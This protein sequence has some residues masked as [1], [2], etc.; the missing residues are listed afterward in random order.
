MR[1]R[2]PTTA[3]YAITACLVLSTTT[4]CDPPKPPRPLQIEPAP[5]SPPSPAVETPPLASDKVLAKAPLEAPS[6]PDAPT[7]D[8]GPAGPKPP[9]PPV[10][11]EL[12]PPA[13][14]RLTGFSAAEVVKTKVESYFQ[15]K[16]GRRIH[17]QTDKPLYKPGETI[18]V[19][20]W[21]VTTRALSGK[22][23]S[24]GMHVE[25]VSPRGAQV[26]KK[27]VHENA[28][29]GQID[30]VLDGGIVGGEYKLKVKT[31]DGVQEER[32]LIVST[33]DPPKLKLKLEFVRKAYG[34][35]DEVTATIAVKR[36]TGEPL[37]NHGLTATVMLDGQALPQVQLRTDE[38]GD[39]LVRFNL[40]A[41]ISQG[42]G[43]LTVMADDGGITESIAKRVPILV[44]KLQLSLY[45]EGGELVS[46]LPGRVYFEAKNPIGKPADI[47]GRVLDENDQ[48]MASFESVRDGLG[49]VDFTP[50][51]GHRYTVAVDQPVGI[52]DR[53]VLPTPQEQGCVLRSVDDLDGQLTATRV[54]VRCSDRRKVVV[55]ATLRESLLD[56]A[57][58]EADRD[59]AVVYLEPRGQGTEALGRA[60]GAVRVTLF[61][62]SYLPLAE[63]LV[64]RQRRAR[65]QVEVAPQK[66]SFVP[67]EK[68][69]L[70]VTT[71]DPAGNPVPADLA[72]SIVDD[73]V[74]SF[75]DDKTGN[76]LSRLYLEPELTGKV[77]EPNF[78]FDL[79]EKKSALA[80]DLLMG[81]RGYRRFEWRPVLGGLIA[82]A[83]AKASAAGEGTA[84]TV[85]GFA[86]LRK[87]GRTLPPADA[88]KADPQKDAPKL[89]LAANKPADVA[90]KG[91][92]APAQPVTAAA[93]PMVMADNKPAT[94]GPMLG[95][96]AAPQRQ[97]A[98]GGMAMAPAA[99][100]AVAQAAMAPAKMHAEMAAEGSVAPMEMKADKAARP[101][102][103][104]MMARK[105][106]EAPMGRAARDDVDGL[107]GFADEIGGG[108]GHGMRPV[109]PMPRPRPRPRPVEPW[110]PVRVFPVPAY[111]PDYSGPRTDFRETIF[112][113]PAVQ[114]GQD[115][116]AQV[117]FFLSD[118]VTSFRV[119]TEAIG[120]GAAGRDE[121]VVKSSLPF[122]MAV[123]LPTE[124]SEGDRIALPL[125]LVN[126]RDRP[127]QV[128]LSAQFGSLLKLER[129]VERAQGLIAPM[130]RD[131]LFYPLTVSGKKGKT[132]I[133]FVADAAGLRD[134]FVREIAVAP[135]G[136]PQTVSKSGRLK[137]SLSHELE[138]A[139]LMEG[140]A[141]GQLKVYISQVSTLIGGLDGMLSEPGGCFEQASS[142]NYPN[143]MILRYLKTAQ[144]AA[145]RVTAR[146][147]ALL[148]DGYKLLTGYET[149]TK[150]YEWFGSTPGHEAL[151]AYGL[152][153]FTD[154]KQVFPEVS[155]AMIKRTADWL[156]A[157]RD[158]KGGFHRDAKSLDSF[159]SA[160][161][162]VTDAYITYSVSEAK[163]PGFEREL[164]AQEQVARET[165]DP[166]ILSLA[167]NTLFN[168][169]RKDTG[170]AAAK[171]LSS[172]Q[173]PSG[174]WKGASHSITRSGG[175]DLQIETTSLAMLA[176]L[177]SGQFDDSVEKGM[178]WLMQKRGGHGSFGATQATVLALKAI[179]AY[180]SA[181]A[182]ALTP[183]T[184]TLVINSKEVGQKSY[185]PGDREPLTFPGLAK[186]LVAG[187]NRVEIRH[188]GQTP[189]PYS[190]GLSY[191]SE[192]PAT[193]PDTKVALTTTL[194]RNQ[195]KLG[196][197]VR[198]EVTLTNK[199]DQG[200]PMTLA[201]IEIPGGLQFQ[202]WQLKELREKGLIG[203]YE[204]RP[205]QVNLY[206][207]QMQPKQEVKLPLDLMATVPG[208]YTAQA[209]TAY[210]YYTSE[211]KAWVAGTKIAIE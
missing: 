125:I 32:P 121:T 119:Q 45:P 11:A 25:L 31:F 58:V 169:G 38:E 18:W 200:L 103:E 195:V 117:S 133:R 151:T 28:G 167:V 40:P 63:R 95:G 79:S 203:F 170:Y 171:R 141:D 162:A 98:G 43:L 188:S 80:L 168:A 27:R 206:L 123:K 59:P 20:V 44:K 77:E 37:R 129:P 33:Y 201:R 2:R 139:G 116:K 190:L 150:G 159:G 145:P 86:D 61:D 85:T 142:T 204:T 132:E 154:M 23:A 185:Q 34:P 122:S 152:V 3:L 164:D 191:R 17:I 88:P 160:S 1:L 76:M 62:E 175:T 149:P 156:H 81:T 4:F 197:S 49:R 120:G 127:V 10:P 208:D 93:K 186:Y 176:L 115:G 184:V 46:G 51:P 210:L 50:Q 189:L 21:D 131:A 48:T 183:G 166:Y 12:A 73:T 7:V 82:Q 153:E 207:R 101:A 163:Q 29:A 130:A 177:K 94:R 148:G 42:D 71:R 36:N 100:P 91:T 52:V 75:A 9:L 35:G 68:V 97:G 114:T 13:S 209:S 165:Q 158:G 157:R 211:H 161:K 14:P 147:H 110:A 83:K 41:D 198:M 60:Q 172:L 69:T 57:A 109:M 194:A 106:M 30:F 99:P 113:S 108:R 65:L 6:P 134:E 174:V 199:T 102:A 182:R 135:R 72:L 173:D 56:V 47:A 89:V 146:A 64:Y 92:K 178:E 187:K 128:N 107:L 70:D 192:Q 180:S 39:G 112:W 105:K 8:S 111:Q 22:H 54:T 138:L 84:Q 55:A 136:F 118:A 196:E 24:S 15:G 67:R 143:V 66:K 104:P 78:Y 5:V 137:D 124:V 205:R 144:I 126:E 16:A 193:S 181:R 74:L 19:R 87:T 179:T 155:G 96:L 140:T 202:T 26:A 90:T 53:F